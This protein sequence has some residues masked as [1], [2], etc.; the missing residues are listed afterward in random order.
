M[1]FKMPF[2]MPENN[3]TEDM[4]VHEGSSLPLPSNEVALTPPVHEEPEPSQDFQLPSLNQPGKDVSSIVS[5]PVM[6]TRGLEVVALRDGFYNRSRIPKGQT[7]FIRN[8]EDIGDWMK[9][10]DPYWE[11]KNVEYHKLKKARK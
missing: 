10:V 3:N 5:A 9:C 8:F 1:K 4:P 7:F 6:S 2:P 11:K